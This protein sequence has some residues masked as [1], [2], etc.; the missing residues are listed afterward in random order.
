MEYLNDKDLLKNFLVK[1]CQHLF[2]IIMK[3]S[4]LKRNNILRFFPEDNS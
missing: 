2:H 1:I 3:D 4:K